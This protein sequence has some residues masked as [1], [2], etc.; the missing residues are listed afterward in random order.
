[1]PVPDVERLTDHTIWTLE[2]GGH[3]ATA[4][5]RKVAG[6]GVELRFEWDGDV[7]QSHIYRDVIELAAAA[8]IKRRALVEQGWRDVP[9][10]VWTN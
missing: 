3:R 9:P 4:S 1:M 2:K 5:T 7:R 6:V 10:I 8:D